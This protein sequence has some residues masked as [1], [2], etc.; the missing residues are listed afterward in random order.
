MCLNAM[1]LAGFVPSVA[2]DNLCGETWENA[3]FAARGDKSG[4]VTMSKTPKVNNAAQLRTH[5]VMGEGGTAQK[6]HQVPGY[7]GYVPKIYAQNIYGRT[8][9]TTQSIAAQ[10]S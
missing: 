3:Q 6:K 10:N 5:T 4:T 8:F 1:S 9:E 2:S 7:S